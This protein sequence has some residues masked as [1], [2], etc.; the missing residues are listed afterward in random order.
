[1]ARGPWGMYPAWAV[2]GRMASVVL[3]IGLPTFGLVGGE[4]F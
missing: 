2:K 3:R 4:G 1:M